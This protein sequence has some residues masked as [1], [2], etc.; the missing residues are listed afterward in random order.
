MCM[1]IPGKVEDIRDGR[2]MVRLAGT[3]QEAHAYESINIGDY[4][5]LQAGLVVK[6]ISKE[7]AEAIIEAYS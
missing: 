7:E 5:F 4:V 3:L 6:K 2:A 1:G